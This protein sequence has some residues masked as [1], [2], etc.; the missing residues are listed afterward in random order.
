M[1]EIRH[2]ALYTRADLVGMLGPLGIDPDAWIGRIRPVKRFR[3]AWWGADL[4]KAIE[5]APALGEPEGTEKAGDLMATMPAAGVV[6][7]KR[8]SAPSSKPADNKP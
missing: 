7:A 4:I 1:I 8:R 5:A 6:E 2:N 3:Q